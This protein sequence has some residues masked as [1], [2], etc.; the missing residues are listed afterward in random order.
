ME[1]IKVSKHGAILIST[2]TTRLIRDGEKE[3]KGIRRWGNIVTNIMTPA[4]R[5]AAMRAIFMFHC[6]GQSHKTL[7]T[8]HNLFEEKGEPKRNRAEALLFTSLTPYR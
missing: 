4:L 8:N 2:E 3:G 1:K 5:W 7:S 6:E